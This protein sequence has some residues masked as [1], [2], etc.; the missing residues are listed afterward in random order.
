MSRGEE[1]HQTGGCM[2]KVEELGHLVWSCL[3]GRKDCTENVNSLRAVLEPE[4]FRMLDSISTE[5]PASI[6]LD[7]AQDTSLLILP[8]VLFLERH[9]EGN[10]R[11]SNE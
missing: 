8:S 5:T 7:Q 3:S 6:S 2:G 11:A 10:L 4:T 1:V 9:P